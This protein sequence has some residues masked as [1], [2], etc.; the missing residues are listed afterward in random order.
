MTFDSDRLVSAASVE[1]I[2][3][4]VRQSDYD[5]GLEPPRADNR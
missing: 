1:R 5:R 2:E 3:Q 4:R